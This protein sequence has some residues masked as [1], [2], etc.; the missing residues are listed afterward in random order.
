MGSSVEQP[1]NNTRS[2]ATFKSGKQWLQCSKCW[3]YQICPEC[4]ENYGDVF[5]GHVQ[6]C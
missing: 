4:K 5:D 3:N 2:T 6:G 1:P